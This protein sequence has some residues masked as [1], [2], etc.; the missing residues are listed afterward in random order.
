VERPARDVISGRENMAPR[1]RTFSQAPQAVRSARGRRWNGVSPPSACARRTLQS[2]KCDTFGLTTS[3]HRLGNISGT[4]AAQAVR[5]IHSSPSIATESFTKFA[6]RRQ[7]VIC[8][9]KSEQ[10]FEVQPACCGSIS[11]SCE[12]SERNRGPHAESRTSDFSGRTCPM[13]PR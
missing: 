7:K 12:A 6:S 3:V 9:T 4:A 13:N 11:I 8:V 5:G 10:T 1:A 2:D